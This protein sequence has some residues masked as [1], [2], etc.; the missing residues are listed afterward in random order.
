MERREQ[1]RDGG[2]SRGAER[3]S[4]GGR[5]EFASGRSPASQKE[6]ASGRVS[7][8]QKELASGRVPASQKELVSG[9]APAAQWR[10]ESPET[11]AR[12]APAGRQAPSG[13]KKSRARGRQSV[14]RSFFLGFLLTLLAFLAGVGIGWYRGGRTEEGGQDLTAIKAPDWVEQA[15][16]RK[17]IYSRPAVTRH[18]VNDI[19]IHYVANVKAPTAMQN[20][21][22]FDNLADQTGEDAA[23]ASSHFVIGVEGEIVQCV[24]VS[25]LSY[26]S[27]YRNIDTVSIECCHPDETGKFTQATYDSLVRLTAWLCDETGISRKHVIRHYDV[28]GKACPLYFVEN[29]DAWEEFLKD[30]ERYKEP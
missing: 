30:V 6:L 22:Y 12:K 24:P 14:D 25:E 7:A 2:R 3:M 23:S 13:P 21:N 27:N 5:K 11:T 10:L 8:G 9:R 16:I 29:E 18:E 1:L 28:N 15:L 19:V 4:N 17:N 26:T 20:R